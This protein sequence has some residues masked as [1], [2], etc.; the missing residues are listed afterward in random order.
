[1]VQ[2]AAVGGVDT[3]PVSFRRMMAASISK[4]G[5]VRIATGVTRAMVAGALS[6]LF[7]AHT[8]TT[9]PITMLPESPRNTE[10]GGKL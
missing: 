5:M 8:P 10:A 9:R 6:A 4:N 1:M 2:V 7:D 3:A